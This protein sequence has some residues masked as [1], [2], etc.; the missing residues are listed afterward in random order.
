MPL[1]ALWIGTWEVI[2]Q[3]ILP[4]F[5]ILSRYGIKFPATLLEAKF[6]S[7]IFILNR[8]Y[9]FNYD[10]YKSYLMPELNVSLRK[11]FI[12]V[13]VTITQVFN[14]IDKVI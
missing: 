10:S 7:Y 5:I 1:E 13:Y 14:M 4:P 9:A 12:M 8:V 11:I 6:N 3:W 2:L